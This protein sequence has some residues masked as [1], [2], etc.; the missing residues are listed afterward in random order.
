[1]APWEDFDATFHFSRNFTYDGK[2][3]E[4]I[5]SNRRSLENQ[6]FVD[7][8]LS[9][10]GVKA[11][12]K[13]YP[14]RSNQDLRT[15]YKQIVASPFPS[16]HKQSLIYYILRDCRSP[17]DA[18]AQFA[19]K[20]YLP[21]KYKLFIDGLWYLDRLEFRR[22]LESLTEPSLIPTFPDEILY[23]LTLQKLPRH[24][25]SLAMAY[26]LTVSPPLASEKVQRAFFETL[27][28]SSITEAFYF[29]RKHGEASRKNYIE[30]LV[31]FVHRS[32]AGQSRSNLAMELVNLP[33]DET[34]EEWFEDVLLRGKAKALHGAKDTVLMR[35]LATGK[36]KDHS[37]E[38]ESLG[39][40]KIDGL[41][42]DDLR[43]SMNKHAQL[44]SAPGHSGEIP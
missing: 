20:C 15:L 19:R 31:V 12:T 34:E 26:Y 14:P 21:E 23:V 25:D 36:L 2:L 30:Q 4:Q 5:Q 13:T 11:V 44:L 10:L 28:R 41:N 1:M 37:A 35:R 22:A 8:L 16:H 40:Q 39:G 42:W 24:D 29:S 33:F 9:L 32:S 6:L 17:N 43:Q 7:R 3:V 38:V 18:A 27:C